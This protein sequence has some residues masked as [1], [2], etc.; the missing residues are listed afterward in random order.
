MVGFDKSS[1]AETSD[2]RPIL[3]RQLVSLHLLL[4]EHAAGDLNPSAT[5]ALLLSVAQSWDLALR[6]G[7]QGLTFEGAPIEYLTTPPEGSDGFFSLVLADG[8]TVVP[9]E[10]IA[11][12]DGPIRLHGKKI[13]LPQSAIDCLEGA[14]ALIELDEMDCAGSA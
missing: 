5:A 11:A 2:M 6:V 9:G 4:R 12:E 7:V 3:F 13:S 8:R 14:I 10:E 1:I